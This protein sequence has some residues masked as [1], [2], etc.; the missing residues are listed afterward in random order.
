[1]DS[2][3]EYFRNADIAVLALPSNFTYGTAIVERGA[4]EI[5]A[6]TSTTV[7]AWAGGLEGTVRQGG[8]SRRRV[9][10][11]LSG[12]QLSWH[13]TGNP[14]AHDIFCKHCVAVALFLKNAE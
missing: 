13:C 12:D 3:Q 6:R 7:E 9:Q 1:M 5:I 2:L 10:L 11:R 4:V 14:K 8:G